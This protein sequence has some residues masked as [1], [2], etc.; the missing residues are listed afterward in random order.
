M[1]YFIKLKKTLS[2]FTTKQNVVSKDINVP[3]NVLKKL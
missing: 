3:S 2:V 1:N